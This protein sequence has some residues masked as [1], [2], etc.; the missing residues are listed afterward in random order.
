MAS[1]V[2][3]SS[4]VDVAASNARLSKEIDALPVPST[5]PAARKKP[6][7]SQRLVMILQ[8]LNPLFYARIAQSFIYSVLESYKE[9]GAATLNAPRLTAGEMAFEPTAAPMSPSANAYAVSDLSA[10]EVNDQFVTVAPEFEYL[11]QLNLSMATGSALMTQSTLMGESQRVD[12]SEQA[13]ASTLAAADPKPQANA[14]VNESTPPAAVHSA[15]AV[16]SSDN[17]PNGSPRKQSE[18]FD[19][20]ALGTNEVITEA[21]A[22]S[23]VASKPGDVVLD[24]SKKHKRNKNK[25]KNKNKNKNNIK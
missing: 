3:S 4:S 21:E 1:A 11:P 14:P 6:T 16:N 5:T 18:E 19:P 7:A 23:E 13:A 24:A 20:E 9:T 2:H 10:I 15:K 12:P 17:V 25:S 22:E 8:Y